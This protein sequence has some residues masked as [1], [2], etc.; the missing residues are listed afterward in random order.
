MSIFFP[1]TSRRL[2]Y[3]QRRTTVLDY[4]DRKKP[5]GESSTSSDNPDSDDES[6]ILQKLVDAPKGEQ[7]S[8]ELVLRKGIVHPHPTS[9][10]RRSKSPKETEEANL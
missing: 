2:I 8:Y 10:V 1:K 7:G 6:K 3:L 9:R 4:T 5:P